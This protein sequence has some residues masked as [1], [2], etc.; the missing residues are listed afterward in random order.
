MGYYTELVLSFELKKDAPDKIV[1]TLK[2]MIDCGAKTYHD[3]LDDKFLDVD[4]RCKFM[5]CS[6]SYYFAYP[7]SLSDIHYN[8]ITGTHH[9]SVRCSFKNYDNEINTFLTWIVPYIDPFGEDFLGY[10]MS[11][12]AEEPTLIYM[13]DYK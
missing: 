11:E 2:Y 3:N 12:E 4:N 10:Y 5:L 13:K 6:S 1:N 9:V 7:A 8:E